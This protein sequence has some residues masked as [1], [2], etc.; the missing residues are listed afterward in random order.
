M[1]KETFEY[2]LSPLDQSKRIAAPADEQIILQYGEVYSIQP[3][4]PLEEWTINDVTHLMPKRPL[5]EALYIGQT[6]KDTVT[7]HGIGPM[8]NQRKSHILNLVYNKTYEFVFVGISAQQHPWHLHGYTMD[9]TGAGVFNKS[10]D[11]ENAGL[12]ECG[13]NR[14]GKVK[15]TVLK[16]I[17]PDWREPAV[18]LT[19]GDSFTVP[20][21]GYSIFRM[22]MTNQGPWLF[23]CHVDWHAGMGMTMI[24]SV[25]KN[26]TY[27]DIVAPPA[28]FPGYVPLTAWSKKEAAVEP[29]MASGSDGFGISF[30]LA[31]ISFVLFSY[32]FAW[33]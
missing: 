9:F 27:P 25:E 16:T 8:G 32:V 23:H 3:G 4:E 11:F 29:A 6:I 22:T 12:D 17:L 21:Y 13:Y 28:D 7:N 15:E 20:R 31:L 19:T 10:T 18:I 5:L 26:G 1:E 33:V 2:Q 30:R 24:F 14:T